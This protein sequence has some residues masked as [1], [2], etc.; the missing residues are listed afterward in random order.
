MFT[1]RNLYMN[2]YI[3]TSKI[4]IYIHHLPKLKTIQ[5]SFNRVSGQ[6][7]WEIHTKE[8]YSGIKKGQTA[9]I[10]ENFNESQMHYTE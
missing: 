10:Y 2:I 6:G 3:T 4:Y 8:S 5:A 7:N 1:H 9:R